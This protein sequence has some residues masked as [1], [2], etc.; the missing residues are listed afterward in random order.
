MKENINRRDF[1]KSIGAGGAYLIVRNIAPKGSVEQ[2]LKVSQLSDTQTS[3]KKWGMV[4]D[5]G[6]CVG[7]RQCVY[8][9]KEE[10]NIP[11]SPMP[12]QWIE[13]FEMDQKE[14]ITR[15][16]SVPPSN[17]KTEYTDSPKAGK[18]YLPAQ[19]V[20][21]EDPPCVKLC[22][23]GATFI[24]EDGIVEMDYDK[25]IGCRQ[26]M[27]ACPYNA[28]SFNW[29]PPEIP[30]EDINPLVPVRPV[31]VVEK[32]TFCIHRVREGRL[33][34]CVEACPVGARHFG[35]LNDPNSAV[36]K[37]LDKYISTT[38]L[39]EMNTHPKLF[40]ITSGNKWLEEG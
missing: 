20:H 10:N 36:S 14:P 35:D 39:E 2:V 31:G 5:V 11:N 25:C 6:A 17:S 16:F 9:C 1:L 19:C 12:M 28:R 13:T 3:G 15:V 8:A 24:G 23:T 34:A 7:C 33:P 21:C 37:I 38:T 4:I 32:C 27:A 26:C 18:W 29:G 40:Y 22:P 30:D